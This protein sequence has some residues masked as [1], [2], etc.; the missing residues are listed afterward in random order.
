MPRGSAELA[1][2]RRQP[3]IGDRLPGICSDDLPC[4]Q[5][6]IFIVPVEILRRRDLSEPNGASRVPRAQR[7]ILLNCF[8]SL[9]PAPRKDQGGSLDAKCV[10]AV[11]VDC[12]SLLGFLDR[13]F[14]VTLQKNGEC[15]PRTDFRVVFI[16]RDRLPCE[17]FAEQATF[18]NRITPKTEDAAM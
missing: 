9:L 13:P 6:C 18:R 7:Q 15:K 1:Q 17:R 4:C 12:Q 5:H 2:G 3:A 16:E 14:D 10:G 8:A 11:F